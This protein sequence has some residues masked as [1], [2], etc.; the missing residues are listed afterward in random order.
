MID[1]K[2]IPPSNIA[3]GEQDTFE[4]FAR[5]FFHCLGYEI[6]ENP[7]RG[8]D[9]G[10]DL[11]IKEKRTGVSEIVTEVKWLVSCKHF[12]HSKKSVT[13]SIEQ[14]IKDRLSAN[15]C[16][17]FIGFYSTVPSEGLS[18]MLKNIPTQIFDLKKIEEQILGN[19]KMS[20]IFLRYFPKSFKLWEQLNV[21]NHPIK[22]FEYYL[23]AEHKDDLDTLN[24][25]FLN[26]DN[27]YIALLKTNNF[28]SFLDY[29]QI[30]F[31]KVNG[32]EESL[33]KLYVEHT[34]AH[35]QPKTFELFFRFPGVFLNH[36]LL[37]RNHEPEKLVTVRW[38]GNSVYI[39]S[40]NTL[41][42]D[43]NGYQYLVN[44]YKKLKA[45]F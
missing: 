29:K 28:L 45:V 15:D 34:K 42:V 24:H 13:P 1:F 23:K 14:N 21:P 20:L 25:L 35:G 11:I 3:N 8:A 17:G 40:S 43:V 32:L 6:L 27:L 4:L 30:K 26:I 18:K 9:G 39:L 33:N 41:I 37:K 31:F 38:T 19:E 36:Y 16:G 7:A 44:L 10:R 2:E 12:G 5:D 22:L